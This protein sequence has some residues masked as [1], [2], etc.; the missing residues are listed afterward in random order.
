[1]RLICADGHKLLCSLLH[2]QE[3]LQLKCK[4]C[5]FVSDVDPRLRL[6]GFVVKNPPENKISKEEKK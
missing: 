5:G 4:A 2:T 3:N 1:M 6:N